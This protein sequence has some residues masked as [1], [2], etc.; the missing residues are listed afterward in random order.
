MY[1]DYFQFL[2]RKKKIFLTQT[3]NLSPGSEQ[4]MIDEPSDSLEVWEKYVDEVFEISTT[5]I[6]SIEMG[7]SAPWYVRESYG[8]I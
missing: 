7:D 3:H 4:C 8:L 5:C 2:E 1:G 6:A